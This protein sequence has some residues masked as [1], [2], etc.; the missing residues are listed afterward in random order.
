METNQ[1]LQQF[2]ASMLFD[3]VFDH[4]V[5]HNTFVT[6]TAQTKDTQGIRIW[7]KDMIVAVLTDDGCT[8]IIMGPGINAWKNNTDG[9]V[10]L[11]Y[12]QGSNSDLIEL[13]NDDS[14]W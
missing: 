1:P 9:L 2:E 12:A 14:S 3:R 13:Y 8:K 11:T 6:S 7:K 4:I 5:K 10:T